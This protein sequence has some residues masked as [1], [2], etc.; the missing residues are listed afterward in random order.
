MKLS[1]K[2][3]LFVFFFLL[4]QVIWFN[5]ILLFGKFSPLV[6]ILPLLLLPIQKNETTSI[7]IAFF[8]G[9]FMDISLGT[10]GVFVATS[11]IVVYFRKIYFIFIKNQSQDLENIEP[12][13]LTISIKFFYYLVFIFISQMLI[14]SLES[15][16]IS[17]I[18]NKMPIIIGNTITTLFFFLFIDIVFINSKEK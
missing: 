17:L 4:L 3:I 16:N 8:V 14:Y 1:I 7:L 13:K 11:L 18:V 10:G 6:Y 12:S 15:F 5:H 2:N 9:L